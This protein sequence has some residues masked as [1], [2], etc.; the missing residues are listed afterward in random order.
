MG[1]LTGP[2]TTI[3]NTDNEAAMKDHII[4]PQ[5]RNNYTWRFLALSATEQNIFHVVATTEYEARQQSP[6]GCVLVFAGRLPVKE[7]HHA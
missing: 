1:T 5:G 6:A 3:V 7:V 4:H 2:L